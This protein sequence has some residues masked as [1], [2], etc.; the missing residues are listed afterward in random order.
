[1]MQPMRKRRALIMVMTF[2]AGAAWAGPW[3][4]PGDTGLRHDI[5]VLADAG[6]IKS[7][8]TTW[9]LSWGDIADSLDTVGRSLS[10]IE[11]VALMRLKRRINEET[12][13]GNMSLNLHGSV[14]EKPRQIRSFE[15]GPREDGEVG[16]GASWT[17]NRFAVNLQGQWVADPQ[18]DREFRPDGSYLGAA[19]GNWMLS[20]AAMDRWWGPGWQGSLIMSNNARPVPSVAIERNSTAPFRSR[21]LSWIGPWDLVFFYGLLEGGR[22]ISDAQ[23]YG[24]RV[25]LRPLRGL[26]IGFSRAAQL[27][28]DGRPC[29]LDTFIDS[30]LGRDNQGE[31]I[32]PADEPGNQ[33]GGIDIRWSGKTFGLPYALYTQ[34]IG[35]DENNFFPTQWMGQFGAETWGFWESVGSYRIYIEWSDTECN[36]KFYR[37]VRNDDSPGEE[38]PGCAYNHPIYASGYR[39]R[40]RSIGHSFDSDSSVFTL[41]GVLNDNKDRAWIATAAAGNLRRRRTGFSS[42]AQNKTRYR[43]VEIVHKREAWSGILN[44]GV[45]YDSREDTVTDVSDDDVRIFVEWGMSY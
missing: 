41:G 5:Q 25:N 16:I 4:A 23:M 19:L 3:L 38:S 22:A 8:I 37:S 39:Y 12:S 33:L 26:E 13:V 31:N 44:V 15:D 32:D 45:G 7:A 43:E 28:G 10:P 17:G 18:D 1:M 11:S 21:W 34:W 9:P 30:F 35:E 2:L 24:M 20:V 6:V 27:C 42:V 29:D 14:A 36:F 40:G